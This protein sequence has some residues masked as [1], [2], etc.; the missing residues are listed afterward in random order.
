[1]ACR[2][3]TRL[4]HR[5]PLPHRTCKTH[6]MHPKNQAYTRQNYSISTDTHYCDIS[7]S[8]Q[9]VFHDS[10]HTVCFDMQSCFFFLQAAATYLQDRI[11]ALRKDIDKHGKVKTKKGQQAPPASKVSRLHSFLSSLSLSPFF[12]VTL[13]FLPFLPF[14][15]SLSLSLSSMS[16]SPFSPFILPSFPFFHVTLPFLPF[17]SS[18]F[19]FL[20]F[21]FVLLSSLREC[22]NVWILWGGMWWIKQRMQHSLVIPATQRQQP[23]GCLQRPFSRLAACA[24]PS[25]HRLTACHVV[26]LANLSQTKW[27]T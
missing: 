2:T 6:P 24:P 5:A 21:S 23:R 14:H 10:C 4:T 18:L 8:V 16:L 7:S 11:E 3:C 26:L 25:M 1:M 9:K 13:P 19:S 22:S 15:S 20:H 12:H 17:H 27:T